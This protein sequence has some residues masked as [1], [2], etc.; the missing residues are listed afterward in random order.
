VN[1]GHIAANR[2]RGG[3]SHLALI[4]PTISG[5]LIDGRRSFGVGGTFN[6]VPESIDL[7]WEWADG[8]V[9]EFGY[10]SYKWNE[11]DVAKQVR[12]AVI[13]HIGGE[14]IRNASALVGPISELDMTGQV[15]G[16]TRTSANTV[17][18]MTFTTSLAGAAGLVDGDELRLT[19]ASDHGMTSVISTHV[20]TLLRSEIDDN[21]TIDW[22]RAVPAF[23]PAVLAANDY[24]AVKPAAYTGYGAE[25]EGFFGTIIGP[26]NYVPHA[27]WANLD[28]GFDPAQWVAG[29]VTTPEFPTNANVTV[30]ISAGAMAVH[31]APSGGNPCTVAYA[32]KKTLN[33]DAFADG[34]FFG[35]AI[36]ADASAT[37]GAFYIH[38]GP[39]AT[40]GYR[41]FFANGGVGLAGFNGGAGDGL[42]GG[43]WDHT[44][45]RVQIIR[46]GDNLVVQGAL[47]AA[48]VVP[49]V[50]DWVDLIVFAMGG[51][52][53]WNKADPVHFWVGAGAWNAGAAL[54]DIILDDFNTNGAF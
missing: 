17:T 32:G 52:P 12:F 24:I 5:P 11:I 46:R 14:A 9:V 43:T 8:T 49:A 37:N 19:R 25:K 28:S 47:P 22:S 44:Y 48:P 1:V 38:M 21:S 2:R 50:G 45:N 4:A 51:W 33:A 18:P 36:V 54:S 3:V 35:F 41:W 42:G 13:G 6:F 26:T 15:V 30:G 34:K 29:N 7:Q 40:H 16:L 23:N 10:D 27:V 53:Y 39:D 31:N 20:L